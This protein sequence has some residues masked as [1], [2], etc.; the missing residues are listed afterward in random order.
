VTTLL[1]PT[2]SAEREA[3]V[4]RE[5][6]SIPEAGLIV[7]PPQKCIERINEYR[8]SGIDTFLFSIPVDANSRY[9]H[10]AGQEVLSAF[11]V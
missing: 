10:T 8:E 9:L 6:A 1:A 4:R 7:G 2:D 11:N 5:F 3:Q